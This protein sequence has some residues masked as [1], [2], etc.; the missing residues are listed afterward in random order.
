[1]NGKGEGGGQVGMQKVYNPMDRY[2][3]EVKCEYQLDSGCLQGCV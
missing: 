3:S 2:E 1:M